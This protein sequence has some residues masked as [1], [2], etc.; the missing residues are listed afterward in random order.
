MPQIENA[1]GI[2]FTAASP[3]SVAAFDKTVHKYL[4]FRKDTGEALKALLEIEPDMPMAICLRGNFFMLMGVRGLVGKA[5]QTAQKLEQRA[6]DL[7]ARERL[8]AAALLAWSSDSLTRATQIWDE[9]AAQYPRDIFAIKMAHFG[10][11]YLGNSRGIRDCVAR[12]LDFW[13]ERDDAHS[14]LMSMY[15]FGLEECGNPWQAEAIARDA[16]ARQPADPWGIHAVAHALEATAR[17]A[18]G[19]AWIELVGDHA[20]DH[21]NFRYHLAWHKALFR[22]EQGDYAGALRDFDDF[23]FADNATEYLDI[24]NDASMLMR[25]ELGGAAPGDRWRAVAAKVEGRVDER[26]LA[27]SDVHYVLALSSSPDIAHREMAR[28]MLASM[29]TYAG[30]GADNALS[31]RVA[32]V[33]AARALLAFRDQQYGD[34]VRY[35]DQAGPG[36]HCMGGSNAQRDLFSELKSAALYHHAPQ[37]TDTVSFLAVRS[38]THPG[39]RRNWTLYLD[40]LAR[41]G[42]RLASQA[43]HARAAKALD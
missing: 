5:L 42:D 18:D 38:H 31:Y 24:C 7:N 23:V 29:E 27:F 28:S 34:A 22:F 8:H 14:Y 9:I 39:N 43:A 21:N 19:I 33:P 13:S 15:A 25:L 32:A 41:Q 35:L 36:L 37:S 17:T 20:K 1:H 4:S 16:V 30:T 11:F 40:T 2:A 12:A 6:A 3:A 26:V 10:H